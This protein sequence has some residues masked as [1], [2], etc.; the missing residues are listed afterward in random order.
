MGIVWNS[1]PRRI[2]ESGSG[3]SSEMM[4]FKAPQMTSG[5]SHSRSRKAMKRIR[6]GILSIVALGV[7]GN[8][9]AQTR[10]P[11]A[12]ENASPHAFLDNHISCDQPKLPEGGVAGS[13]M[14]TF[15]GP[16]HHL[17]EMS[18]LLRTVGMFGADDRRTQDAYARENGINQT[19]VQ[20]FH[21]TSDAVMLFSSDC[22]AVNGVIKIAVVD[23]PD[24][25]TEEE[26]ANEQKKTLLGIQRRYAATGTLSCPRGKASANLTLVNDVITTAAHVF[27][28][29]KTC[30]QH[31]QI[32]QCKFVIKTG[33][34][35]Q[36]LELG[37]LVDTGYKCPPLL[38]DPTRDWVVIKLKKPVKS[39]IPYSVTPS[40]HVSADSRLTAVQAQSYDFWRGTKRKRY[41]PKSIGTCSSKKI[42]FGE[43]E[44]SFFSTNCDAAQGGSGG[45]LLDD[46]SSAP[47]LLGII[48]GGNETNSQLDQAVDRGTPNTGAYREASWASYAVPVR[49]NFLEAI[50]SASREGNKGD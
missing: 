2:L 49:G 31:T 48:E 45:A 42:Y 28:D 17:T 7:S 16:A 12:I 50:L 35:A 38:P 3:C 5:R 22:G 24:R 33:Q 29:S 11:T 44:E 23:E 37:A 18:S 6:V 20:P 43:I 32:G 13:P 41:F 21:G 19:S 8:A 40:S 30:D 4:M 34:V 10:T 46:A 25:R 26:F 36:E 1:A 9:Y 15:W 14:Q 27:I 47:V 39:V